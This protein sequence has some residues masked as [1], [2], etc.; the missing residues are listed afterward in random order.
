MEKENYIQEQ[1]DNVN[2][3]NA[4]N[5]KHSNTMKTFDRLINTLDSGGEQISELKNIVSQEKPPKLKSKKKITY[6]TM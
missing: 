3:K 1:M 2:R 4:R 5:T 6:K